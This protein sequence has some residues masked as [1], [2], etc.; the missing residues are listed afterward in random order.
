MVH[1]IINA[2]NNYE[3]G[4][5]DSPSHSGETK[6][7]FDGT[8]TPMSGAYENAHCVVYYIHGACMVQYVVCCGVMSDAMHD[9]A[10]SNH[11]LEQCPSVCLYNT[12]V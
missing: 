7:R 10:K 4:A 5:T 6:L 8:L 2:N 3:H 9:A 12:H 11:L 1:Y